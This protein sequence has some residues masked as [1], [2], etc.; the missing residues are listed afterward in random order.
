MLVLASVGF[1]TQACHPELGSGQ[2]RL[3]SRLSCWTCFSILL[4]D[5]SEL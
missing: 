5:I 4:L 3:D 2:R 1:N